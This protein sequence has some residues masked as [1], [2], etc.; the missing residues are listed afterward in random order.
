MESESVTLNGGIT[1]IGEVRTTNTG[2]SVVNLSVAVSKDKF[3][4]DTKTWENGAGGTYYESVV[5]F[6]PAA[7]RIPET[8]Q[9]GDRI[10]V[11]GSRDPKPEWTDKDGVKHEHDT[12]ITARFI[13]PE[14]LFNK[15]TIE[16]KRRSDSDSVPR[17]SAPAPSQVDP[18]DE[19]DTFD[20][21]GPLGD[22]GDEDW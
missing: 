17:K 5:V 11:S 10:I 6:G 13:G 1:W 9:K 22:D 20:D 3:N 16:R 4:P 18:D 19:E 15:I 7:N 21:D 8:F 12:Q 2:K 14:L